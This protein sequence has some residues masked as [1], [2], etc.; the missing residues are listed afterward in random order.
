M[1]AEVWVVAAAYALGPF[2]GVL[3]AHLISA[4]YTARRTAEELAA[5]LLADEQPGR[6]RA[7][8]T[9][10]ARAT[11]TARPPQHA[12]APLDR[13]PDP[14]WPDTSTQRIPRI[15]AD[16]ETAVIPAATGRLR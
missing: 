13:Q 8:D 10:P 4:P 1:S 15:P 5:I 12:P 6:R 2:C 16:G 11:G 7:A 3:T 9:Q 14:R